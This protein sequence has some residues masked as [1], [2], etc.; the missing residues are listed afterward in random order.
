MLTLR[1]LDGPGRRAYLDDVRPRMVVVRV[2][3]QRVRFAWLVPLWPFEH[4]VAFAVGTALI[5][6]ALWPASVRRPSGAEARA[7]G[8]WA[9]VGEVAELAGTGPADGRTRLAALA[10]S[11]SA[12]AAGGL[13]DQLRLP[14][15][16]PYLRVRSE[17]ATIDIT[18]Y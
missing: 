14:P 17:E 18:A 11:L 5:A 16:V 3:A 2:R 8:L 13:G 15:G 9:Q 7:P 6:R 1:K 10:Q 12:I 4:L